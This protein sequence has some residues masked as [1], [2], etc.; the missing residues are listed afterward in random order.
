MTV[1]FFVTIPFDDIRPKVLCI[2]KKLIIDHCLR[3]Q[4]LKKKERLLVVLVLVVFASGART[5]KMFYFA[6]L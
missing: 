2:H 5:V 1:L 3:L 4:A 6:R